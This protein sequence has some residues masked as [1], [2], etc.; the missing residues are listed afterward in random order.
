MARFTVT[1]IRHLENESHAIISVRDQ[2][3][4]CVATRRIVTNTTDGQNWVV[5]TTLT[6]GAIQEVRAKSLATAW[7]CMGDALVEDRD[8]DDRAN[9][10]I[11][12][13]G[14]KKRSTVT[15]EDAAYL[16]RLSKAALVDILTDT[17]RLTYGSPDVA[18][19]VDRVRE[20]ILPAMISRGDRLPR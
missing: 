6:D 3:Y 12:G 17:L 18:L 1:H 10:T 8:A 14:I 5:Q 9:N 15:G 20:A 13:R 11:R 7:E 19:T 4:P 16:S 2:K